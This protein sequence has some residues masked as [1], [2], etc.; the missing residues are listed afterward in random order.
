MPPSALHISKLPI[1]VPGSHQRADVD[2]CLQ[3]EYAAIFNEIGLGKTTAILEIFRRFKELGLA[4]SL[5]VISKPK[6]VAT[7]W[8][9]EIEKWQQFA[10]FRW[11]LLHG[12][13]R[14]AAARAQADIY[15]C[16]FDSLRWLP[17]IRER[18]DMV[19][20]DES[21]NIKDPNSFR[22]QCAWHMGGR[23][24]YRY[25]L[26]GTPAGEGDQ[27]LFAQ[28]KFLDQGLALGSRH[29]EF[30]A[31]FM[32]KDGPY[33][34]KLK[35]GAKEQIAQRIGHFVRRTT[36]AEAGIVLPALEFKTREVILPDEAM[37]KYRELERLMFTQIDEGEVLPANAAVLT[38]SCRQVANGAVYDSDRIPRV[39]HNAKLDAV[40]EL[41][42]RGKKLVVIYE[43]K[44][45][46]DRL[47]GR[48]G[49]DVP[50]LGG[51]IGPGPARRIIAE[52]N[53]GQHDMIFLQ[54]QSVAEGVNLQQQA[55]DVV[56]FS[57]LWSMRLN[58]QVVGR[59]H[60][61]GQMF[62]V[63]V[64]RLIAKGTIDEVVADRIGSKEASQEE[65]FSL[66]AAYRRRHYT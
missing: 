15:L 53:A 29:S 32:K 30:F 37:E 33:K 21:S 47:R 50:Y 52:W 35:D 34:T 44:H 3:R 8:P 22:T 46:L 20:V 41:A 19:V 56:F 36:R 39:V 51:G 4:Q 59:V 25:I 54:P 18:F 1:W 45:D 38:G 9:N 13:S 65:L 40:Q 17:A 62:P 58:V 14:E 63:D 7:T 26:D 31:R 27:D 12:E 48:F 10:H 49:L 16:P 43:F 60:R 66:L 2:F 42:E 64:W 6:I 5:L 23:A 61:P 28:V 57:N 55:A 11:V 24:K